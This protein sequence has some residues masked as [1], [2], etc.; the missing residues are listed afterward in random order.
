MCWR[1]RRFR[2]Q[3]P[4][5]LRPLRPAPLF[6]ANEETQSSWQSDK[7]DHVSPIP[8]TFVAHS[9]GIHGHID[10]PGSGPPTRELLLP[11]VGTAEVQ[12]HL[13]QK[14]RRK[15]FVPLCRRDSDNYEPALPH[16]RNRKRQDDEGACFTGCAPKQ[17][18]RG[19]NYRTTWSC[20]A[21][22]PTTG[23]GNPLVAR[24]GFSPVS[25]R[26]G[27]RPATVPRTSVTKIT[28]SN[29]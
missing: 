6:L 17:S 3:W 16:C 10:G 13:D 14:R 15:A 28:I 25:N 27:C 20:A 26:G 21:V 19:R 9:I 1:H 12:A 7:I 8:Q 24:S 4:R 22:G 18:H 5:S 2:I 23:H 11:P 29:G